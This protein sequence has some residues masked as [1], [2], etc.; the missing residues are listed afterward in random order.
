VEEV[1]GETDKLM[2]L[3]AITIVP[4]HMILAP[5]N[6]FISTHL[7]G[8]RSVVHVV[9]LARAVEVVLEISA[10]DVT[11]EVRDTFTITE[12]SGVETVGEAEREM[13]AQ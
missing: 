10:E 3:I 11:M 6:M 9:A 8:T 12:T 1:E 4:L 5:V 13:T 2:V 7:C